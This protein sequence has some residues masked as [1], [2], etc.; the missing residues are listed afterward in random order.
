MV[1]KA[2]IRLVA[3]ASRLSQP[4]FPRHRCPVV[5]GDFPTCIGIVRRN[6]P[7]CVRL[8]PIHVVGHTALRSGVELRAREVEETHAVCG[9]IVAGLSVRHCR[10]IGNVTPTLHI[11]CGTVATNALFVVI[12][13][14]CIITVVSE[15]HRHRLR[16]S[17]SSFKRLTTNFNHLAIH[18]TACA[19]Y[20]RI[21]GVFHRD[22]L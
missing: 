21:S 6:H 18:Q 13:V 17:D 9:I 19:C 3:L 20:H 11:S 14:G 15:A 12:E 4:L 22:G 7:Q 16:H 10:R 8:R 2:T 1:P 5:V